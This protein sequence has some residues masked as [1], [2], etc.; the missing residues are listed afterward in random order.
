MR[1]HFQAKP[2]DLYVVEVYASVLAAVILVMDIGDQLATIFVLFVPGYVV[3]AALFP[4]SITSEKSEVDWIDRTVLSLGLSILVVVLLN[5]TL[6]LTPWGTRF[7]TVMAMT[8]LFTIGVGAVAYWRRMHTLP[9]RRLSLTLDLALPEWKEYS[10]LS[11]ILSIGLAA[12]V[13][14]AAFALIYFALTSPPGET[15]TEF[16]ILGPG[17]NASSYPTALNVSQT[18]TVI[19]GIANHESARVNY[20]VRIDL[21]GVRIVYNATSG[22]NETVEVNRTTWST[23]DVTLAHGQ[24]WTQPYTFRINSVGLW[25]VQFLL[26]FENSDLSSANQELH[27]YIRVT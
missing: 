24:N 27:L 5:L 17:G 11:K 23:F 20:T 19:L 3:V 22:F 14:V 6:D 10:L 15:F 21:V 18:G 12:G 7:A 4:G 13:V 1:L 8:S 9:E 2:W 25:K 16:Y 26:L